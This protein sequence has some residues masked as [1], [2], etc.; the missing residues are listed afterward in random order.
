MKRCRKSRLLSW[1]PSNILAKVK[2]C[3]RGWGLLR[4]VFGLESCC[5]SEWVRF[6]TG[7]LFCLFCNIILNVHSKPAIFI[8][9]WQVFVNFV[10]EFEL[11]ICKNNAIYQYDKCTRLYNYGLWSKM[12]LV[13][14]VTFIFHS[15]YRKINYIRLTFYAIL[16]ITK[17]I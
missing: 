15:G 4:P 7:I 9:I 5:H 3:N 11:W 14:W 12:A 13:Y 1:N 2:K 8:E 6:R 10:V 17:N 16:M